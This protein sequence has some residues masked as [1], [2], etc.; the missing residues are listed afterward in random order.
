MDYA[1]ASDDAILAYDKDTAASQNDAYNQV[2]QEA[3]ALAETLSDC[4][5]DQVRSAYLRDIE[6]PGKLYSEARS[7]AATAD[8]FIRDYLGSNGK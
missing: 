4:P 3:A 8:A 7:V 1:I 6:E 5:S 2:D